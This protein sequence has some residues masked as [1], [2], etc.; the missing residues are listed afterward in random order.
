MLRHESQRHYWDLLPKSFLRPK[1]GAK[2]ILLSFAVLALSASLAAYVANSHA[3]LK[4]YERELH[5]LR[6][7]VKRSS[8]QLKDSA[9]RATSVP[10]ESQ[11]EG[12]HS[13]VKRSVHGAPEDI[14]DAPVPAFGA[15]YVRWGR[16]NCLGDSHMVYEGLAAGTHYS[17]SGGGSNYI[18]LDAHTKYTPDKFVEGGQGSSHIYGVEFRDGAWINPLF[19]LQD[20][21]NMAL[22]YHS[23]PCAVCLAEQK[24]NQMMI[25]G[26][27]SCPNGWKK[28]Y[29]GYIMAGSHGDKHPSEYICV[30]ERP[31]VVHGTSGDQKG[32]YLLMVETQCPSLLC[33]PFVAGRELRCV[34]CTI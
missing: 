21:E 29:S 30:D 24:V 18:C 11:A 3:R 16:R 26:R 12:G 20:T 1:Q 31:Q 28:E 15:T 19:D 7:A 17:H 4:R 25:P 23:L 2:T 22:T 14:L 9:K 6:T 32:A 34:V 27:D 10:S 13:I 33:E 5:L 8:A